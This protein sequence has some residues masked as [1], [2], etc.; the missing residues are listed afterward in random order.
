MIF[1]SHGPTIN[2]RMHACIPSEAWG[3]GGLEIDS[4]LGVYELAA[5]AQPKPTFNHTERGT[6]A[7][8]ADTPAYFLAAECSCRNDEGGAPQE[9]REPDE[10]RDGVHRLR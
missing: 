8:A 5:L 9:R 4:L 2:G 6:T 10:P 3:E 7:T 1:G